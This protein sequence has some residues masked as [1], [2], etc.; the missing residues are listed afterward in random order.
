MLR[1]ERPSDRGGALI[2][3][4]MVMS[5]LCTLAAALA[6]V[7]ST[8]SVTAA[9]YAA[10]QQ[11]LYAADA[12]IERAVGELRLLATWRNVPAS[13]AGSSGLNDGLTLARAPDG[14]SVDLVQLTARRQAES[15]ALYPNAPD[16]P[17]WRLFG[18]APMDRMI[19]SAASALP[20]VAVWVADDPDDLDGDPTI[21]TN[22]V[23][24][25][26]AAAFGL[27]G[28]HREAEVTLRREEAMA[29]GLPGVM[30]SDVRLIAWRELR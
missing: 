17:V 3:T 18:H 7:V 6:L 8:E 25:V 10:A 16:R 4:L 14:A 24:M 27:R 1:R 12:G 29:A 19:G 20:Y 2:A 9:N 15:D 11:S 28:G 26:H 13:T 23:V 30:R 5:L 22:D 21:D